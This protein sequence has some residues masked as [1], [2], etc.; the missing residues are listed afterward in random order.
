MNSQTVTS[1]TG[2]VCHPDSAVVVKC[3]RSNLSGAARAVFVVAV[4][5]RHGI[6]IV[7][8]DV[9]T[10]LRILQPITT[11]ITTFNLTILLPKHS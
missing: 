8:V 10:R 11:L 3:N 9:C 4:V 7:V 6:I 2:V 1:N 5:A